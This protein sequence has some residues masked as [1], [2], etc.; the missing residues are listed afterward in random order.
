MEFRDLRLED[1]GRYRCEV[2]DGL[3]DESGLVELEFRGEVLNG[4]IGI[5]GRGRGFRE[6]I[7]LYF[8]Y[9]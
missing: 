7:D 6:G 1:F 3:E 4:V 5:R 2:I 9:R 8:L